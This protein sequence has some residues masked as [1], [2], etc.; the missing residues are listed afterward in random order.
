MPLTE[1]YLLLAAAFV[2]LWFFGLWLGS[3]VCGWRRLAE[4]YRS[5]SSF[6]CEMVQWTSARLGFC[7]YNGVLSVGVSEV[8][9]YVIPVLIYR[10]FHPPLL[11]PWTEIEADVRRSRFS[12]WNSA[13][14]TFPPVPRTAIT[15]YGRVID[16][17]LP[18]IQQDVEV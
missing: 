13:R 14:L 7:N 12:V 17:V 18:Y 4:H 16:S 10:P 5:T 11:I 2:L 9:F 3:R 15:L 8:G 6:D 1:G